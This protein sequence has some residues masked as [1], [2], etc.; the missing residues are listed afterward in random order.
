MSTNGSGY[1]SNATT[2]NYIVTNYLNYEYVNDY[3]TLDVT[4]G[5]S[6]NKSKRRFYEY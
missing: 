1:A 3:S 4:V 6:L 2:E 5:S